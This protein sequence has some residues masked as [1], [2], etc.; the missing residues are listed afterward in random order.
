MAE[1]KDFWVRDNGCYYSW[2]SSSMSFMFV[3]ICPCQILG[4]RYGAGPGGYWG[5]REFVLHLRY[6][7]FRKL[8]VLKG[9]CWQNCHPVFFTILI[10]KQICS[11][12]WRKIF[13]LP[14]K[15]IIGYSDLLEK[16]FKQD[17]ESQKIFME[18]C[19]KDRR[20]DEIQSL[21]LGGRLYYRVSFLLGRPFSLSKLYKFNI[22][23]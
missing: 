15:V 23:W 20:L 22:I 11:L 9:S 7:E 8:S 3:L 18:N 12:P 1:D 13:S 10:R 6:M 4:G 19:L 14:S 16:I 17:L 2:D 21:F 5:Y